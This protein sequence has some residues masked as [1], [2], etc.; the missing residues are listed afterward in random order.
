M[1]RKRITLQDYLKANRIA[2]RELEKEYKGSGFKAVHKIHKS[3]RQYVRKAKHRHKE[4][5]SE[6]E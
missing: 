1:S 6:Q 5:D 3:T 4:E 2:S